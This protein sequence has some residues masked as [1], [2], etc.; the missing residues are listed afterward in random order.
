MIAGTIDKINTINLLQDKMNY[1]DK[2]IANYL[3]VTIKSLREFRVANE[4]FYRLDDTKNNNYLSLAIEFN[5]L[6]SEVYFPVEFARATDVSPYTVNMICKMFNVKPS[7]KAYCKHCGKEVIVK[8]TA[9][10]KFCSASCR[11]KNKGTS[12]C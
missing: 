7:K 10:P 11:N 9:I 12:K 6:A 8:T 2:Q 1:N 4:V 5:K 3:G